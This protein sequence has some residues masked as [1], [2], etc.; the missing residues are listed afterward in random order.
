MKYKIMEKENMIYIEVNQAISCES[1]VLDIIGTCL[2]HGIRR[3]VLREGVLSAEFTN[4]KTGLAGIVLQNFMNYQIKV[5]AILEDKNNIQGRFK[6]LMYELDKNNDFKV[7]D[8]SIDAEN[9]I[10]KVKS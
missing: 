4:L 5:A 6:E 7:F 1:D 8:N 2:S 10:M 3:I 9:W